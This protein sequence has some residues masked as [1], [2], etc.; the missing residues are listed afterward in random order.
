MTGNANAD[1]YRTMGWTGVI[2]NIER[3]DA[4]GLSDKEYAE[5][6]DSQLLSED[7]LADRKAGTV[8]AHQFLAAAGPN[9]EII[10]SR[11]HTVA[12][13][14][15]MLEQYDAYWR[16]EVARATVAL[17]VLDGG[18]ITKC[19]DSPKWNCYGEEV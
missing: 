6:L 3:T 5:L 15:V 16:N 14:Q 4:P 8:V 9:P 1:L 11:R 2:D 7:Q 19:P 17:W 12:L 18:T 13:G 10:I